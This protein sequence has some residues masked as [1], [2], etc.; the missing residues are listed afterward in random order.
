MSTRTKVT[1]PEVLNFIVPKAYTIQEVATNFKVTPA[2]A[3][4]HLLRLVNTKAA[5][6]AGVKPLPTGLRG[7][8]PDLYTANNT[9]AAPA[10]TVSI[11]VPQ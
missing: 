11:S 2:T 4:K 7:R 5:V 9:E 3:R 1:T 6:K 8:S 10:A